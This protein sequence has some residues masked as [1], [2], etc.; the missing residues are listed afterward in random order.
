MENKKAISP[1]ILLGVLAVLGWFAI[2]TQFYLNI[3]SGAASY[4]EI[5]IRFFSYFTILTNLIIAVTSVVVLIKPNSTFGL[6]L[7]K[8]SSLAAI[9]VYII[10]VGLIYN[11]ILR[12]LWAPQGLQRLVDELLHSVIPVLFLIYWL[13]FVPKAKL[14]W[15]D[16]FPW[17]LYPLFYT[18]FILIRGA[19]SNYYPYP[20]INAAELGLQ[21]TL[22]NA[23]GIGVL[24]L[25]LSLLLVAIAK[26]ITN[27]NSSNSFPSS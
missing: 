2:I 11:L 9:T 21:K 20:F 1:K 7:R 15:T 4:S 17:L 26:L 27:R 14:K 10:V 24:F 25:I 13:A 6:F 12:F 19:G 3:T 18:I 23:V 8:A 5:F 22:V 16:V